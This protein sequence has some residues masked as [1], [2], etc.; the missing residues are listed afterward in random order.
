MAGKIKVVYTKSYIGFPVRQKKTV[1]G[2]GLK[3]LNSY[4]ILEDT[5][6]V[7]GMVNKVSHLVTVEEA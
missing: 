6:Q 2:L 7:R 4:K 1:Q 3:K 5:P